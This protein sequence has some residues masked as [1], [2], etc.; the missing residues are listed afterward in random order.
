MRYAASL[1]VLRNLPPECSV[2]KMT[3][4]AGTF[5]FGWMSTGMPR[6]SSTTSRGTVLVE[7][8]GD[9]LGE[10]CQAFIRRVVDDLDQR[11]VGVD[12]VGIH[13]GPMQDRR[14]ILENLDVFGGI[15]VR[16]SLPSFTSLDYC[17]SLRERGAL[18]RGGRLRPI[19]PPGA[20][21]NS[22]TAA[23]RSGPSPAAD[24]IDQRQ[25]LIQLRITFRRLWNRFV[26]GRKLD[27][28]HRR[29]RH[30]ATP[31]GAPRPSRTPG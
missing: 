9:I 17:F 19:H 8:D 7:N 20:A 12:R 2:V 30:R 26:Q 4:T 1:S 16:L 24:R 31:A 29:H 10:T 13:A 22:R 5:F 25:Q 21:R 23:S 14:E 15:P 18:A 28:T 3:W 27:P 11:V 6:P